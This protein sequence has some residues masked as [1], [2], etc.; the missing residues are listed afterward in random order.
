MDVRG[1]ES[2]AAPSRGGS[3]VIVELVDGSGSSSGRLTTLLVLVI[4]VLLLIITLLVLALLS[5]GDGLGFDECKASLGLAS[6]MGERRTPGKAVSRTT[7]ESFARP[8]LQSRPLHAPRQPFGHTEVGRPLLEAPRHELKEVVQRDGSTRSYGRR[9]WLEHVSL[10][11]R[12][13]ADLAGPDED[14]DPDEARTVYAVKGLVPEARPGSAGPTWLA[15]PPE[16]G[17]SQAKKTERPSGDRFQHLEDYDA[18]LDED[19]AWIEHE[20]EVEEDSNASSVFG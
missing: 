9:Q 11:G 8:R 16:D 5:R 2:S 4:L 17:T 14:V 12:E 18:S 6:D 15:L 10:V 13:G 3:R 20:L 19:R 1:R 7:I